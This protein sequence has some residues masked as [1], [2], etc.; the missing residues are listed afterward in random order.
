MAVK[1]GIRNYSRVGNVVTFTVVALNA[2]GSVDTS[3]TG[4]TTFG[5]VNTSTP[6]AYTFVAG[7]Q[8]QRTFSSTIVDTNQRAG[9]AANFPGSGAGA[10][11]SVAGPGGTNNSFGNTGDHLLIGGAGNDTY[12]GNSGNDLFMFQ[13]GGND[14][15][16]GGAGDDGFYFGGAYNA[17]DLIDGGAGTRDQVALQGNYAGGV[18]LGTMANIELL[19]L[20][21]GNDTR[22]GD[23]AGNS[24]SYNLTSPN[25]AVSAG[26]LRTIQANML[27]V[28]ENFTFNGS[29]ETDGSFLIYGGF[30][31]DNLTGGAGNDGFFF[32]PSRFGGGDFVIGG[33]GTSDQLG[34]QGDY[35]GGNAVLFGGS[36]LSGI[37][38]I[39]LLSAGDNRF[40]AVG[41]T[42]D[43][44]LFMADGNVAAGQSLV[45]SANT[46]QAGETLSFDGRAETDGS[47]Q[48]F[49][50]AGDDVLI[51][52][53][54]ADRLS[55]AGGNDFLIG[56]GGAD[57]MSGGTGN[58]QFL[59][60]L[61]ADSTSGARDQIQDFT[62]GDILDLDGVRI[63]TG[64]GNLT[65]I[66]NN[67]QTGARQVQVSQA[68]QIATVNVYI[69]ADAVADMVINV[70]VADSHLLTIADF[71]G[72]S[73]VPQEPLFLKQNDVGLRD[74]VWDGDDNSFSMLRPIDAD[75]G[76]PLHAIS[77]T[78]DLSL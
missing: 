32:G 10:N 12:T 78:G 18:A 47:Y 17:S 37:E 11:L 28:G 3:F 51:G 43:Y 60:N 41:G 55:G 61:A 65:F 64:G 25:A 52:G 6:A 44:S 54:G 22:F 9:L 33:A 34:L 8:G 76:D 66:G 29:A 74:F 45:I 21:P 35:T 46:L 30:G 39:V 23:T 71:N 77:A 48:V 40:G 69:D 75:L 20:L 24:Y 13:D 68:G 36:Q 49:A 5:T 38:F 19:V 67:G 63:N 50:G 57:L 72:V 31:N 2:D 53:Q 16:I 4:T 59:Y 15:G 56:R 70:T 27:R 1:F 58:D 14:V 42:V 26:G 62:L 7:D 73:A